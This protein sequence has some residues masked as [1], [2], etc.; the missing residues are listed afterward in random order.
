VAYRVQAFLVG[1]VIAVFFW[2]LVTTV[3]TT[4]MWLAVTGPC[5]FL[6]ASW[7]GRSTLLREMFGH[8]EV[9]VYT[10]VVWFAAGLPVALPG[11]DPPRGPGFLCAGIAVLGAHGLWAL[12]R[13]PDGVREVHG[14]PFLANVGKSL[15][16]SLPLAIVLGVFVTVMQLLRRMIGY[17][18][19]AVE[20][21]QIPVLAASYLVAAV[22]AGTVIGFLRTLTRWPLGLMLMGIVGALLVYGLVGFV[23]G[24]GGMIEAGG[25]VLA[26]VALAI[27]ISAGP[28]FAYGWVGS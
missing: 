9:A 4:H 28:A 2:L 13:W 22:A 17:E 21:N 7:A 10:M 11:P 1:A 15:R 26:G 14:V 3:P 24:A 18:N 12:G 27:A 23:L 20:L 5:A 16:V 6:F 25:G 8:M 19:H